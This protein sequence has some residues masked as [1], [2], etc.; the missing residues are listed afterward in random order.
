MVGSKAAETAVNEQVNL[1]K[2]ACPNEDEEK[3]EREADDRAANWAARSACA[4]KEDD[5]RDEAR[6]REGENEADLIFAT[7]CIPA[8]ELGLDPACIGQ[9]RLKVELLVDAEEKH[10]QRQSLPEAALAAWRMS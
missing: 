6:G 9:K 3:K 10:D 7:L 1:V 8:M 5:D 2:R 4:A